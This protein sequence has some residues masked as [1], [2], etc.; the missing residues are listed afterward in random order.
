MVGSRVGIWLR[1]LDLMQFGVCLAWIG[2]IGC[3]SR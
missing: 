3:L 1:L 2:W